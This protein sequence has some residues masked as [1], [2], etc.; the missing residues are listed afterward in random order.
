MST[1][2][3]LA[4][5]KAH[6]QALIWLGATKAEIQRAN[7]NYWELARLQLLQDAVVALFAMN[8]K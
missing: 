1:S 5:A 6:L 7:E 8:K 2:D 4:E 3:P